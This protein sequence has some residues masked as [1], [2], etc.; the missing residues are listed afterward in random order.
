MLTLSWPA[1][2]LLRLAPIGHLDPQMFGLAWAVPVD[3]WGQEAE[4]T[5]RDAERVRQFKWALE[6][7][8]PSLPS[9]RQKVLA[10]VVRRLGLTRE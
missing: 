1:V 3:E 5:I 9:D 6:E 10:V 7:L 4:F 8:A 2:H